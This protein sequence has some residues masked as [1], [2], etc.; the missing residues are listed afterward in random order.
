MVTSENAAW[1]PRPRVDNTIVKALAPGG[2]SKEDAGDRRAR[3]AGRSG[4]RHGRGAV[5]RQPV[6]RL[7]LLAPDIVEVILD[8]RQLADLQLDDAGGVSVRVGGPESAPEAPNL[9]VVSSKSY[10][11]TQLYAI[12]N[13]EGRPPGR[14]F[15]FPEPVKALW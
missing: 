12:S 5:L 14:P 13:I 10:L 9:Q 7:K 15:A 6:L 3:H 8:G 2:S 11:R 4:Q 1:A